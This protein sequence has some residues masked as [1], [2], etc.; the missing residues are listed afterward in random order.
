[1]SVKKKLWLR[2]VLVAVSA[3]GAEAAAA[4]HR[5]FAHAPPRAA[6]QGR[7]S[8]GGHVFDPSRR[9]VEGV[10]V[11]LLDEVETVLR[12]VRTDG[13]GRYVFNNLS[14][15]N[16]YVRVLTHGTNLVGQTRRV[17]ITNFLGG[18]A[19]Q[20]YEEHFMLAARPSGGGPAAA[21]SS[22]PGIVFVQEG[23]PE[24]A[25]A[26]YERA[27]KEIERA[28]GDKDSALAELKRAVEIFPTYY[29]ALELLGTEYV[30]RGQ[31]EP[32]RDALL[33]AVEV[34]PRGH[35]SLFALGV[36]QYNLKRRPEAA[37]SLRRSVELNPSSLNSQ[38]WL[39]IVLFKDG[40]AAEAEP[41]LKRAHEL[42]EKRVPDVHMYLAQLY[43]ET[44]RYAQAADE[45][46][47]FLR[48]AP[49]ARDAENI[50]KLIRQLREKAR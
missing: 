9:P 44:R 10:Y 20:S 17:S 14:D 48:E 35:K 36:A 41:H 31:F 3:C 42:G 32:A 13:S 1:M 47:H 46:E 6:W 18:A 15:G 7:N 25:K 45:L 29:M 28:G 39:G 2:V 5:S 22:T 11:E 49:Q 34:N 50:R 12:R 43:S 8:I 27:V 23:V 19:G 40:K 26:A 16:F 37:E 33:K 24:T 30:R 21:S 4:S 38:L